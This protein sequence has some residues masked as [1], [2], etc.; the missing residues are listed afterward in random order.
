[1]FAEH[2]MQGPV[3]GIVGALQAVQRVDQRIAAGQRHGDQVGLHFHFARQGALH[4]HHQLEQRFNQRTDRP[5]NE[6]QHADQHAHPEID[7]ANRN[8]DVVERIAPRDQVAGDLLGDIYP[9]PDRHRALAEVAEFVRQ[10]RAE[11]AQRQ[12]VDQRQPDFQVF[13]RW[14]N[15]VEQ[16]QV[17]EHGGIHARRQEDLVRTRR[18][19]GIGQLVQ[20][21]EQARLLG[22]RDFMQVGRLGVLD[23]EQG[24]DHEAAQKQGAQGHQPRHDAQVGAGAADDDAVGGVEEPAGQRKIQGHEQQQTGNGQP[25]TVLV[26]GAGP[27]QLGGQFAGGRREGGVDDT[28]LRSS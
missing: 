22:G 20:K 1:M 27:G 17:I 18:P 11:L 16:R 13:L 25:C 8:Q 28:L 6:L 10:H 7:V 19:G 24:L 14:E 21:G 4:Q 3:P 12:R 26:G 15:Q 5:D 9:A 2:E 23:R